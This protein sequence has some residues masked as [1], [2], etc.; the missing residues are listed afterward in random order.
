M[1]PLFCVTRTLLNSPSFFFYR[2]NS[3]KGKYFLFWSHNSQRSFTSPFIYP[4]RRRSSSN[5]IHSEPHI[6]ILRVSVYNL[7]PPQVTTRLHHTTGWSGTPYEDKCRVIAIIAQRRR[8]QPPPSFSFY[9]SI[10]LL[11]R[12]KKTLYPHFVSSH[13]TNPLTLYLMKYATAKLRLPNVSWVPW[14]DQDVQNARDTG[15]N[16]GEEWVWVGIQWIP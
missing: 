15:R 13:L 4:K 3:S 14:N 11:Q 10:P 9:I 8:L 1:T 2:E 6:H 16:W 12:K 7:P 5:N